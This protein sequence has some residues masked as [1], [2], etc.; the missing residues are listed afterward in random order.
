MRCATLILLSTF[1]LNLASVSGAETP[2]VEELL[3]YLRIDKAERANLFNGKILSTPVTEGTDKE[4]AVGIVM[5]VP[6]PM[7]ALEEFVKT[8]KLLATD[9]DVI[10]FG[11][12]P[13]SPSVAV[14]K[15]LSGEG[16]ISDVRPG[17]KFNLDSSEIREL[18]TRE[19]TYQGLLLRRYQA[20]C[21]RGLSGIAPYDRGGGKFSKPADELT[22]ALKE[23]TLL[24]EHF[25]ELHRALLD[26]PQHQPNGVTSRFFWVNQRVE[27][28]PTF[29]LTHRLSYVRPEGAFMAERQ[30]YVGHSY[31]SLQI[32]AGCLPVSGGSI[33]FYSN[34]TSTDQ[35][36]GLASGMRHT[37]GRNQMR[38]EITKNFEQIR[39]TLSNRR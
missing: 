18:K 23:S 36:A 29:I 1:T 38:Q 39:A 25:P 12:L 17:A 22:T 7:E 15:G 27:N 34:H 28:R 13:E 33:V 5:F 31:N 10:A 20:Y 35:V 24:A 14:F 30:Y 3:A 19:Q 16:S 11:E 26:Y 8:G 32:L 2:T 9:P 21:A 6:A 37:L 4:L